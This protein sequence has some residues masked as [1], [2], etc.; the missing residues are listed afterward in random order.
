MTRARG[1]LRLVTG[2]FALHLVACD[3]PRVRQPSRLQFWDDGSFLKR[4]SRA[5]RRSLAVPHR[6][7]FL[8]VSRTAVADRRSPMSEAQWRRSRSTD[9]S[10]AGGRRRAPI[11]TDYHVIDG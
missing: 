2:L 1:F 9:C 3:V 6:F 5:K 4:P 8:S 7:D 11:W 10:E